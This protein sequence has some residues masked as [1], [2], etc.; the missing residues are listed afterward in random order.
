MEEQHLERSKNRK[1]S[2]L[3]YRKNSFSS[4]F[5]GIEVEVHRNNSRMQSNDKIISIIGE[6]LLKTLKIHQQI[7]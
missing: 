3:E 6:N 4:K 7:L 5:T 2:Q 1:N